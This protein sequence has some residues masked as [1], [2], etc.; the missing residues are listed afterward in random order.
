[1]LPGFSGSL[2]SEY[3]AESLL[4]EQFGGELGVSGRD[5]AR[6][7]FQRWA[8]GDGRRMGPV[9]LARGVH[10]LAAVPMMRALG[11]DPVILAA[12]AD[13]GVVVCRLV[14]ETAGPLLVVAPW[15][16]PLDTAW[17]AAARHVIAGG[18]DWCFATNGR[19]LR[20]LDVRRALARGFVQFDVEAAVADD[21]SF[22][23][24]W[25]L[26]RREGFEATPLIERVALASSRHTVG[27]CRSLRSGVLDAV[28]QL[29]AGF[30]GR[31]GLGPDDQPSRLD[32]LHEQALTIV[33]RILFLLFAE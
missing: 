22:G 32:R 14:R 13:G 28:E 12:V 26:L 15:A 17:T 27:V 31:T 10:D 24:F 30:A 16:G 18:A 2:V 33:Y 21:A 25:G 1:M 8:R 3:F 19:E 11:F 5:A 6:T 9:T 4:Q 29:L 7:L 23:V 20:L